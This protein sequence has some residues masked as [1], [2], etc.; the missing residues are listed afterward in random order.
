MMRLFKR[1]CAGHRPP[2]PVTL[3]PIGV[4]CNK[5]KTPRRHGWER[6]ESR[7]ILRDD[8]RPML[9][10]LEDFSHLIVV[11]VAH[12][13]PDDLDVEMQRRPAGESGPEVGLLATRSQLRPNHLLVSAVR[14]LRIEG[15]E[16]RVRGLDAVDGSPLLDVK[17]YVPY[18]DAVD[19]ARVAPWVTK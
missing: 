3:Q 1:A 5:V 9:R 7:L 14:L 15:T 17:P 12:L 4:V 10:G 13:I 8:L 18:Y 19:G 6:I 11:T 2:P 16:L